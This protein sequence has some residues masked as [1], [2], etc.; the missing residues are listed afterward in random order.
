MDIA[1]VGLVCTFLA[2]T[3]LEF[4]QQ[5]VQEVVHIIV[6]F[7]SKYVVLFLII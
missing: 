5:L 2:P 6:A 7:Y 3:L 4:S 1:A